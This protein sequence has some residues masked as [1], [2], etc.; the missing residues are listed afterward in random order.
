MSRRRWACPS[1]KHPGVL[2]PGRLQKNDV[3]RYCLP[4]STETGKLVERVCPALEKRRQERIQQRQ[5]TERKKRAS[6]RKAQQTRAARHRERRTVSIRDHEIDLHE[7]LKWLWDRP[8]IQ[9]AISRHTLET[10]T[11]VYRPFLVLR[12]ATR[13]IPAMNATGCA[14]DNPLKVVMTLGSAKNP[15]AA[16]TT[17]L[18]ELVHCA[19][20]IHHDH[21]GVFYRCMVEA[22]EEAWGISVPVSRLAYVTDVRL[23]VAMIDAL[24][25]GTFRIR[26]RKKLQLESPQL[27][28]W[29]ESRQLWLKV[30]GA[31]P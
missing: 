31:K 15:V 17:L 11:E 9:K 21:D 3:R 12:H 18:H 14:W 8:R 23:E 25:T 7:E 10:S 22:A 16:L 26:K 28:K 6:V 2:A 4:C 20:G 30:K 27:N 19:V 29:R 5:R 13:L 1:E 24:K